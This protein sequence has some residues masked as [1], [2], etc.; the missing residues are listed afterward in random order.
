VLRSV[1]LNASY[2]WRKISTD[3]KRAALYAHTITAQHAQ[4]KRTIKPETV[5]NSVVYVANA[6]V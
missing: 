4:R 5:E 2:G 1:A 6:I 3:A